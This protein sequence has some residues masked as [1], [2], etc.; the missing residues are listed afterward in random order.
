MGEVL[1]EPFL[2]KNLSHCVKSVGEAISVV[3]LPSVVEEVSAKLFLYNKSAPA[4]GG[5][6]SRAA[7]GGYQW[8]NLHKKLEVRKKQKRMKKRY[9]QAV[10]VSE[11]NIIRKDDMNGKYEK[12]GF[13]RSRWNAVALR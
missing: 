12:S 3:S 5:S 8:T 11:I 4:C 9:T 2:Y 7:E 13:V 1:A 10:I 6:G